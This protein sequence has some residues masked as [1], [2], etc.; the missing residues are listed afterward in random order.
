MILV[1][2]VAKGQPAAECTECGARAAVL[3]SFDNVPTAMGVDEVAIG[4]CAEHFNHLRSELQHI[5][6]CL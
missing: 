6:D 2:I 1:Q 3:I 5:W 4:L